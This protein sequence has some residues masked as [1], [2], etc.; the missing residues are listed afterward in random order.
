MIANFA[1]HSCLEHC[2][3]ALKFQFSRKT[4]NYFFIVNLKK[5]YF[6]SILAYLFFKQ[7]QKIKCSYCSYYYSNVFPTEGRILLR[8]SK[9]K[10]NWSYVCLSIRRKKSTQ[11]GSRKLLKI[12]KNLWSQKNH[13]S[14]IFLG[15]DLRQDTKGVSSAGVLFCYKL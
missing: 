12:S 8:T 11:F 13:D 1:L 4:N 6:S 3:L 2:F 7:S 10:S 9:K 5:N 15:T 14:P